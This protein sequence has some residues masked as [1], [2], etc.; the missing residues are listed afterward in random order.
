MYKLIL[1]IL[2]LM[3][4]VTDSYSQ[5]KMFTVDKKS[6]YEL[7]FVN[8]TFWEN[9]QDWLDDNKRR[10]N[11]NLKF[12]LDLDTLRGFSIANK[13]V[14]NELSVKWLGDSTHHF[15]LCWYHYFIYVVKDGEIV[16]ELRVNTE[17]K[18]VVSHQGMYF[19]KDFSFDNLDKSNK[20]SVV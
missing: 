9:E 19:Y 12:V 5:T 14:V 17:C 7:Y 2:G 4:L 1:S 3:T 13:K 11:E 18:Q 15:L 16:D 10:D 20:I 8:V 6:K